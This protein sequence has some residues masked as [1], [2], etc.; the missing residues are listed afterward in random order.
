[1]ERLDESEGEVADDVQVDGAGTI[2]VAAQI[3]PK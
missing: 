2:A 1:M 3:A